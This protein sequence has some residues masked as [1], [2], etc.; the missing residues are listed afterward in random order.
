[1]NK[2]PWLL[3]YGQRD[4]SISAYSRDPCGAME[5]NVV[6]GASGMGWGVSGQVGSFIPE[7]ISEQLWVTE[8]DQKGHDIQDSVLGRNP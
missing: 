1:M 3:S 7:A 8:M 5:E 2:R 6:V 4:A